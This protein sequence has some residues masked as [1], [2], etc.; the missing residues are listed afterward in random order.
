MR[1]T[2]IVPLAAASKP[3]GRKAG[4]GVWVLGWDGTGQT[5]P[6]SEREKEIDPET[7]A[8]IGR[9]SCKKKRVRAKGRIYRANLQILSKSEALLKQQVT[10]GNS[11]LRSS[12]ISAPK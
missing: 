6:K 3:Q 8:L 2:L 12:F 10:S 1:A 11:V 5:F 9:K 7:D 4:G